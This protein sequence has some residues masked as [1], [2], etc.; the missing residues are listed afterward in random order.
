MIFMPSS[1]LETG[2]IPEKKTDNNY[3]LELF[4]EASGAKRETL[5]QFK[6]FLEG[7][8]KLPKDTFQAA[9][10]V[11]EFLIKDGYQYDDKTFLL[12]DV[13]KNKKGNCLGLCLFFGAML[14]SRGFSPEFK[15]IL[16]PHDA[17]YR[18]ED[19][20]FRE[21]ASGEHFSYDQPVLPKKQA[22]NPVARYVPLEH[23]V[24]VLDGKTFETTSLDD[25]TENPGFSPEAELVREATY[26]EV[27]SNVYLDLDK[28]L[29]KERGDNYAEDLKI[30]EKAL[31]LGP[32]NRE[33]YFHVWRLATA[34]D[35]EDKAEEMKKKY[36][37]FNGKDSKYFFNA[38]IMS[39]DEGY[40]DKA[41]AACPSYIEA[42]AAKHVAREQ[43]KR[44]ATFNLAVAAN[45]VA[46]SHVLDL[47]IF[48]R[49]YNIW[50]SYILDI[51]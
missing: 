47:K 22:A 28:K 30:S 21:L 51:K 1:H 38:F 20:M 14:K 36:F 42:F 7:V 40:L 5:D 41:L 26:E 31:R 32:K 9:E 11:R 29:M 34:N 48:L 50:M 27:T 19:K 13:L 23:P 46:N 18:F 25:Q 43:D 39:G 49:G 6:K 37:S 33:G 44:E 10:A 45:C 4:G 15:I 35:D 24:L 3:Y 16:N 2:I 12:Q 8:P 17:V